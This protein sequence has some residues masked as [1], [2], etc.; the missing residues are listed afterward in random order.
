MSRTA[1]GI[2]RPPSLPA[3]GPGARTAPQ[4]RRPHLERYARAAFLVPALAYLLLAFAL[5]VV[6]N[7]LLSFEHTSPATI[8]DLVAPFA[9]AANYKATLLQSTTQSVIL[10]TLI[11]TAGSLFFQFMIGLGL[12]LLLNVRFP[13]KTL[14]RSVI[15]VPWLLPLLVT[16][17]IF[18]FLFQLEQGAV[19]QILVYLHLVSHP[20]GFLLTPGWAFVSI[21][22]TNIWIGFPFF[23]LMLYSALQEVPE[24]LKEAAVLDGANTWQRLTRVTLPIIR[25]VIEVVLVLGF[26]F[27]VKVFDVVIGLTGGGPENS[28]QLLATWAYNQSFQQFDYGAGAVVNTVLLIFALLAAPAYIWLNKESL[29]AA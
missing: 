12:A 17:I 2:R 22:I 10:R 6:Y 8:A 20:I 16:G 1:T 19:N 7:T 4:G 3:A 14:A 29:R 27:T 5:P 13:F 26:V 23:T 25:P 18:R 11:F 24:E 15:I 28:T 9:G 21:L